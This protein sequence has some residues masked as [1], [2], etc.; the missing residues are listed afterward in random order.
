M[1]RLLRID[2]LKLANYKAFWVLNILYAILI[3]GV[4]VGVMEFLKWL[5]RIGSDFE[6]F[7][8]MRIPVLHFPDI[9]Q[10]ITFV[11]TFF[12]IFVAIIVVISISNEF[13]YKT[14]R[15]NVIDGFSR[16]DFIKSKMSTILLLAIGSTLLVFLT[17]TLTGIIYSPKFEFATMFT[18]A[19]FIFAYFID[20][21]AF[22]TFTFFITVYL[23]RSALT[24]FILILYP[25]VEAIIAALLPDSIAVIGEYFPLQA[26]SNMIEV[27]FPRYAFQE[28]TDYEPIKW[29]LVS[30]GWI[31]VFL[32]GIFAKLK[33]S[34]V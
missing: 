8:P 21:F 5:K 11:Y 30:L 13:S 12:K 27:P 23:K 2:L 10:N 32:Y 31:G 15:Q 26:I 33:A 14:I 34:D 22:L 16:L 7:D 28:I 3:V 1:L 17:G 4:P 19:E 20:L 9:W 29:V 6:G 18:N 24:V 25:L